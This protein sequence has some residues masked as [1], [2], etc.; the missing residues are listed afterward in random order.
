M[1]TF[2]N[3]IKQ[4]ERFNSRFKGADRETLYEN[5]YKMIVLKKD[6]YD[7]LMMQSEGFRENKDNNRADSYKDI[8]EMFDNEYTST[9][10][11]DALFHYIPRAEHEMLL[12]AERGGK[13]ESVLMYVH[14]ISKA[15]S[16]LAK[17]IRKLYWELIKYTTLYF[18]MFY[19]MPL[20]LE[21]LYAGRESELHYGLPKRFMD[22]SLFVQNYWIPIIS[23]VAAYLLSYMVLR[24]KRPN[25]F[26]SFLDSFPLYKLFR[27]NQATSSLISLSLEMHLSPGDNEAKIV[28]RVAEDSNRWSRGHLNRMAVNLEQGL[29]SFQQA[30]GQCG[31]FTRSLRSKIKMVQAVTSNEEGLIEAALHAADLEAQGI[32]KKAD[33]IANILP[34]GITIISTTLMV[35]LSF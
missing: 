22:A 16:L 35:M 23:C 32:S 19:Y 29:A 5:L 26:R 9:P 21:K 24:N 2:K 20:A 30:M 18:L 14:K 6:I 7:S 31:L 33:L 4:I 28:R 3:I 27:S 1:A 15:N 11:S 12:K 17:S 10:L 13:L 8:A 34:Q 25:P